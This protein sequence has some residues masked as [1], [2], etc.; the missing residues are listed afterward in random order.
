MNRGGRASQVVDLIHLQKNRLDDVVSD[1]LEPG[2]PKAV[3]QVLL[4]AG[5]EIVND[6]H[7]VPS[8]EK[9]VDEVA[10]DES[11]PTGDHDP[12]SPP[13]DPGW[14]PPDL[15]ESPWVM[16]RGLAVMGG[17]QGA[18]DDGGRGGGG[19]GLGWA[20]AGEGRLEDEECGADENADKDE[21][22]PLL[23][24]KIVEGSRERSRVLEGFGR[25]RGGWPQP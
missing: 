4:P 12:R 11:R 16:G 13:S 8:I 22:E 2:V 14:N 21:E 15:A 1:E 18:W 24:Q 23:F 3:H 17:G 9:L 20:E 19:V 7:I 5:E 25:V 10:A 6:D